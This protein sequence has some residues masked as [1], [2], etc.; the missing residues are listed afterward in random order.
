M[1]LLVVQDLSNFVGKRGFEHMNKLVERE[2][3]VDS[4]RVKVPLTPNFFF[5][6]TFA[7]A[8]FTRR[9]SVFLALDFSFRCFTLSKQRKLA[10]LAHGRQCWGLEAR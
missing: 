6:L 2:A 10:F 7:T 4:L 8:L 3:F 9:K 5:T 1:C